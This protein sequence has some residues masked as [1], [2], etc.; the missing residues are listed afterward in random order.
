MPREGSF[1]HA[2]LHRVPTSVW[3]R[4]TSKAKCPGRKNTPSK[5]ENREEEMEGKAETRVMVPFALPTSVFPQKSMCS[6]E[7]GRPATQT[8]IK[9]LNR[10]PGKHRL[11]AA[12]RSR[13][14]RGNGAGYAIYKQ[15]AGENSPTHRVLPLECQQCR[16][17][18]FTLL[19]CF[20]FLI[21]AKK[22]LKQQLTEQLLY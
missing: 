9:S 7:V 10:Q 6:N 4:K 8:C 16:E 21:V 5:A 13:A 11:T 17:A 14:H 2:Q 20:A 12:P 22:N 18:V 3:H 1:Q 19:P 15:L